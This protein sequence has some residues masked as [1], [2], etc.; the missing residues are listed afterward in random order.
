MALRL[1]YQWRTCTFNLSI[2]VHIRSDVSAFSYLPALL[3]QQAGGNK[4]V[5]RSKIYNK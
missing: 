2:N 4:K 1:L 3:V 5:Q